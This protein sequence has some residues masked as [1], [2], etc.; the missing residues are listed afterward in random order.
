MR[1][2]REEV[3]FRGLFFWMRLLLLLLLF[4]GVFECV[5]SCACARALSASFL[6]LCASFGLFFDFCFMG[7]GVLYNF[8][9][10]CICGDGIWNL[11]IDLSFLLFFFNQI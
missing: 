4:V 8:A 7:E 2:M 6:F 5:C 10:Y 11:D 1:R 9:L 3:E